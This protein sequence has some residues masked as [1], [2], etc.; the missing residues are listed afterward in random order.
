VITLV[1]TRH[2]FDCERAP[3]PPQDP[4]RP[5]N[6]NDVKKIPKSPGIGSHHIA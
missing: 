6:A 2:L 1:A 5:F 3:A 4:H